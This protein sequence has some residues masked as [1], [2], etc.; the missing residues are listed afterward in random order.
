MPNDHPLRQIC[1]GALIALPLWAVAPPKLA[2][3]EPATEMTPLTYP[4][5]QRGDVVDEYF[6]TE[7]A[8]PYR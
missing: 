4:E 6:G 7:V 3:T 5:T 1:L 2:Q 8:D